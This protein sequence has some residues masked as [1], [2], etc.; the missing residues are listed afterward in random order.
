MPNLEN[1]P[2]QQEDSLPQNDNP[3]VTEMDEIH[4]YSQIPEET[5]TIALNKD[6]AY[7]VPS[8]TGIDE[9]WE[10]ARNL[11]RPQE[12]KDFYAN[13]PE[14]VKY[15]FNKNL[16]STV[17]SS[18]FAINGLIGGGNLEDWHSAYGKQMEKYDEREDMRHSAGNPLVRAVVNSGGMLPYMS[19]SIAA[20]YVG[21]QVGGGVGFALAPHVPWASYTGGRTV[22]SVIG[23]FSSTF[24]TE[25]GGIGID[26]MDSG[27]TDPVAIRTM[28]IV[29]GFISAAIESGQVALI[30]GNAI[31]GRASK[32][33]TRNGVK[34]AVMELY[35]K[36]GSRKAMRALGIGL[37]KFSKNFSGYMGKEVGAEMGQELTSQTSALLAEVW[38]DVEVREW[39]EIAE[40]VLISG[41]QAASGFPLLYPAGKGFDMYSARKVKSSVKQHLGTTFDEKINHASD[42]DD[43]DQ[44]RDYAGKWMEENVS[45]EYLDSLGGI[46]RNVLLDNLWEMGQER[47]RDEAVRRAGEREWE[48]PY[49]LSA[50]QTHQEHRLGMV[51]YPERYQNYK[52]IDLVSYG[53]IEQVDGV[54]TVSTVVIDVNNLAHSDFVGDLEVMQQASVSRTGIQ[55][56]VEPGE[57]GSNFSKSYIDAASEYASEVDKP[58]E[59]REAKH[60]NDVKTVNGNMNQFTLNLTKDGK[61]MLWI[62]KNSKLKTGKNQK[63]L[64]KKEKGILRGIARQRG[65]LLK[66]DPK[67]G[68][69]I[70]EY[71]KGENASNLRHAR[72]WE[73]I[74]NTTLAQA[75]KGESNDLSIEQMDTAQQKASVIQVTT[76]EMTVDIP[77]G[78]RDEHILKGLGNFF[79]ALKGRST[80]KTDVKV[81]VTVLK[82]LASKLEY[83]RRHGYHIP[84]DVELLNQALMKPYGEM[85]VGDL[86]YI[87]NT[88]AIIKHKMENAN[89]FNV[90]SKKTLSSIL[91]DMGKK[92]KILPS[93]KGAA[94]SSTQFKLAE[95]KKTTTRAAREKFEKFYASNLNLGTIFHDIDGATNLES[96]D[97]PGPFSDAFFRVH[98]QVQEKEEALAQHIKSIKAIYKGINVDESLIAEIAINMEG[99]VEAGIEGIDSVTVDTAMM[100]Y[101]S[102]YAYASRAHLNIAQDKFFNELIAKVNMN[103]D[104]KYKDVVHQMFDY[105]D[106]Y[107][108]PRLNAEYR[109]QNGI[110]LKREQFYVPLLQIGSESLVD[111]TV[112]SYFNA[113]YDVRAIL[114]RTTNNHTSLGYKNYNYLDTIIRGIATT[115]HYI[116]MSGISQD[117]RKIFNNDQMQEA[118]A[119]KTNE[120]TV[121]MINNWIRD[122]ENG[123]IAPQHLK[124]WEETLRDLRYK[125]VP[126]ILALR[127][128]TIM[129]QPA[130][131]IFA[132]EYIGWDNLYKGFQAFTEDPEGLTFTVDSK[133]KLVRNRGINM[134]R[135]FLERANAYA[136]SA[137]IADKKAFVDWLMSAILSIDKGTVVPVWY[138]AYIK[139][140]EA[141]TLTNTAE[142]EAAA[143]RYA[144][145]VVFETQPTGNLTYLPDIFRGGELARQYTVFKN[146]RSKNVN[147]IQNAFIEWKNS[148]RG[149][150]DHL[151]FARRA[152]LPHLLNAAWMLFVGSMTGLTAPSGATITSGLMGMYTGGIPGLAEWTNFMAYFISGKPYIGLLQMIPLA[153]QV[154][155]DAGSSMRDAVEGDYLDSATNLAKATGK[156]IGGPVQVPFTTAQ[157]LLKFND[158]VN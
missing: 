46:E 3:F 2:M 54:D 16:D 4:D 156:V 97:S 29:G 146:Q 60:P 66:S 138:G 77:Q 128:S 155:L 140:L 37:L 142:K 64:D 147:F 5:S 78:H 24:L 69:V 139:N 104:K 48:Q 125:A 52:K 72:T 112:D 14:T 94:K 100:L 41:G 17:A 126:A 61:Q 74:D 75:E 33:G 148:K 65:I 30:A 12:F 110:D 45:Q 130:S 42:F 43:I 119:N 99:D 122:N 88:M 18:A 158:M 92:I 34:R 13:F 118:I 111:A 143:R 152:T 85:S 25:S 105:F 116:N 23:M 27:V 36:K 141:S 157:W 106:N 62:D 55:L 53:T 71:M 44:W 6:R 1:N 73:K 153:S 91:M 124:A 121:E 40:A 154:V 89:K 136:Q 9:V 133:T 120:A 108:Y 82:N 137:K 79:A 109:K 131:M 49:E 7:E 59:E 51:E 84:V 81:D 149:A 123:S 67:T 80:N 102:Q 68:K 47:N 95:E 39:K 134:D 145:T 98:E 38:G 8:Y 57:N 151:K 150:I 135:D 101:A 96:M 90:Y 113:A 32:E 144:D 87:G 76:A 22:G 28:S 26:I 50:E 56:G 35:K 70:V 107:L 21:G 31:L 117:L 103:L 115:E 20:S 86:E 114:N 15:N 132:A 11:M 83:F 58:V 129:K 93:K 19:M 127:L 63:A 10:D